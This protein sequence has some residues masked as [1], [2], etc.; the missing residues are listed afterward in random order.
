[1]IDYPRQLLAFL[2]RAEDPVGIRGILRALS[3]PAS[4][5]Q[6]V[7]SVLTELVREGK[8]IKAGSRFWVPDGTRI[9]RQV[10]RAKTKQSKQLT[11]RLSRNQRGDG[12]V[13]AVEGRDWY[14]PEESLA[15][16]QHGDIVCVQYEGYGKYGRKMGRVVSIERR[17]RESIVVAVVRDGRFLTQVP[18]GS[19]FIP[20]SEL[21]QGSKAPLREGTLQLWRRGKSGF[22]YDRDLGDI[23][24]AALDET[25]AL[26][27]SGIDREFPATVLD[28][29]SSIDDAAV[30]SVGDREDLRHTNLFTVDGADARDFDDAIH[31]K[32]SGSGFELGIHI[33]DVSHFVAEDSALDRWALRLGNSTYL[34]HRAFPML[35]EVLSSGLCSLVPGEDRYTVS[36]VLALDKKGKVISRR[37]FKSVICSAHRLT[38][39]QV[40]Q[41]GIQRDPEVREQFNQVVDDIDLAL[42]IAE[43]L[44]RKRRKQ[45]S[46]GLDLGEVT[47]SLNP[48]QG[49]EHLE[50][51]RSHEGHRMIEMF[52]VL[53]N[54]IISEHMTAAGVTVPFRSHEPPRQESLELLAELMSAR[55]FNT[56]TLIS[57]PSRG[58][59]HLLEQIQQV[60]EHKRRVYQVFVLR[61]L[62][63]AVY[64]TENQGHFGLGSTSY[65]HFTSPIRRYADLIVHRRLTAILARP[66][67]GPEHFDDRTLVATCD[68]ISQTERRSARAENLFIKLKTLRLLKPRSGDVMSGLVTDVRSIGLF[69]ELDDLWVDGLV[70]MDYLND[71]I[72]E[73]S[74]RDRTLVGTVKGTRYS[75]GDRLDVR[76]ERVDLISR[77]IDLSLPNMRPMMGRGRASGRSQG[78]RRRRSS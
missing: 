2:S 3:L 10:K 35:P 62:K 9:A 18:L 7:R 49:L 29:A 44:Y 17:D 32:R 8:V 19:F 58:I 42:T 37:V 11:G 68:H 64:S 22:S 74:A 67:L 70:P 48:E 21:K 1:M 12:F 38:Y 14:V 13:N 61:S 76:V 28:E 54:E 16:A 23:H 66:E 72:Y 24:D 27:E 45:G 15:G 78:Q 46:L 56:D 39:E 71:D 26:I 6:Y 4:D 20:S 69:V 57:D 41:M 51:V 47:A 30:F 25:V 31:V 59:N 75:I 73:I 5:R 40:H 36:V 53:A 77:R 60:E 52:M 50:M 43:L 33:A 63:L 55:G 65:C 34:P